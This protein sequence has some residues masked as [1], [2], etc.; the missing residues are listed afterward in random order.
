MALDIISVLASG[1]FSSALATTVTLMV[2]RRR[3]SRERRLDCLRRVAAYRAPPPSDDWIE[4]LNE[5]FVTFNESDRVMKAVATASRE[6]Q[7]PSGLQNGTLLDLVK[8]MMDDLKLSKD[9]IDD[10]FIMRPFQA[11]SRP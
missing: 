3:A 5:I 10:A 11:A 4:A 2:Q 8:S 9:H 7:S 6:T 1:V